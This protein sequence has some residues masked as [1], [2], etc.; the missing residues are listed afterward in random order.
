MLELSLKYPTEPK[1]APM[2]ADV[3]VDAARRISGEVL[4]YSPRS[5]KWVDDQ[6]GKFAA[7]GLTGE[8]MAETI[9][10]FGCYVGE[11][12]IRNLGGRWLLT[13]ESAMAG[14]TPWPLVVLLENGDHWNPIGKAFKRV[15]E[16]EGESIAYLY[17]I[18]SKGRRRE[19]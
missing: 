10:C 14:L 16:G 12:L 6:L 11:V 8:Q 4:D 5:L 2:L 9:F 13:S 1:Y 19:A 15:D 17:S 7:E 18:A 3:S